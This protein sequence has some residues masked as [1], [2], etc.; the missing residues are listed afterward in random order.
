MLQ[1]LRAQRYE[2]SVMTLPESEYERELV[3]L[4]AEYFLLPGL[5]DMLRRNTCISSSSGAGLFTQ[6]GAG[7]VRVWG[8]TFVSSS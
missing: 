7:A 4:E 6:V 1:Y 5:V 3:K 8:G 2:D